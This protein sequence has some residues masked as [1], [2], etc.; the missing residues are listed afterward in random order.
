M[1]KKY[2]IIMKAHYLDG[3]TIQDLVDLFKEEFSQEAWYRYYPDSLLIEVANSSAY[4][5]ERAK[6]LAFDL[7]WCKDKSINGFAI[8]KEKQN[9]I[10]DPL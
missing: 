10:L 3:D 7:G 2:W 4:E 8:K 6:A 1:K 9:I 5:L